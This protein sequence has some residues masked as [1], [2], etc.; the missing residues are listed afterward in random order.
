MGIKLY[1]LNLIFKV[2]EKNFLITLVASLIIILFGFI[3][4]NGESSSIDGNSESC[5]SDN[6]YAIFVVVAK[7]Y[8]K[9]TRKF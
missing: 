3:I 2:N 9:R 6:S 8:M 4:M 1:V 5:L 7:N